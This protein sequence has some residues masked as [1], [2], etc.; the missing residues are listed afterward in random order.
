[1][2]ARLTPDQKVALLYTNACKVIKHWSA[3]AG[4]LIKINTDGAFHQQNKQGGWGFVA[5]DQHGLARAAGAGHL[6]AVASAAQ[7][8]AIACREAL[9]AASDWGM[10]QVI[11][12]TDSSNLVRAVLGTDFDRAPEGVLYRDIRAICRLNFS[13]C[14]FVYC[15]RDCNK[16]AHALGAVGAG[17]LESKR[18]WLDDVP[19]FV[20]VLVAGDITEPLF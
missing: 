14:Q 10:T 9:M 17:Q 8:E 12:E 15:P 13:L 19:D 7:A 18:L 1:M 4:D 3:P 16:V 2:V 5:R 20:M 6:N 11:I